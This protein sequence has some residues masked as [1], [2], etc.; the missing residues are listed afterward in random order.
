MIPRCPV[1]G[2]AEDRKNQAVGHSH[3]PLEV[4]GNCGP[5]A[6]YHVMFGDYQRLSLREKTIDFEHHVLSM[7]RPPG[8]STRR[9]AAHSL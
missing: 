4:Q 5:Q 6:I 7:R 1:R 9:N 3:L 2:K 8:P